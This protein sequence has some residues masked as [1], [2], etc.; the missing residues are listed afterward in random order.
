LRLDGPFQIPTARSKA[1]RLCNNPGPAAAQVPVMTPFTP[2]DIPFLLHF[3][4][5]SPYG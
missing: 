1:A 4:H 5:G 3:L 2:R